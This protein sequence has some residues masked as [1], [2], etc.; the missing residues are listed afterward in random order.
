MTDETTKK[1][2]RP[3]SLSPTSFKAVVEAV[4]KSA[5]AS[6]PPHPK[7][8]T[9][10]MTAL[11]LL[12]AS[13]SDWGAMY[14]LY[15][16][17]IDG[18]VPEAYRIYVIAAIAVIGAPSA[19]GSFLSRFFGKGPPAG[20]ATALLAAVAA[21]AGIGG[22][23]KGSGLL[24]LVLLLVGCGATVYESTLATINTTADSVNQAQPAVLALC[25]VDPGQRCDDARKAY[26]VAEAAVA[27]A[28]D[29][30]E[31]YRVTG[32]GLDAV[33]YAV[34]KAAESARE[35]ARVSAQ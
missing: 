3:T 23:L 28:H 18:I 17:L 8:T 14:F 29:A 2:P 5:A 11:G 24:G 21:K 6:L 27:A 34:R 26:E 10:R 25:Q 20:S 19:V 9:S 22:M 30:L 35:V 16:L 33:G 12:A 13:F 15:R 1:I 31:A 4:E 32:E 7:T